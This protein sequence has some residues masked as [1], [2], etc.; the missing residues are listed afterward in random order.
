VSGGPVRSQ[1]VR[2]LLLQNRKLGVRAPE[3]GRSLA[4]FNVER[5]LSL[6]EDLAGRVALVHFWTSSRIDCQHVLAEIS[7]LERRFAREPFAVVSC[8]SPKFTHERDP[9]GVRDAI[10]RLGVAHP[11]AVECV[12]AHDESSLARRYAVRAWPTSTL[13]GPDGLLLAQISGEGQRATLEL[14]IGEALALYRHEGELAPRPLALRS[15]RS[16]EAQRA[17][18][19]PTKLAWNA[20][21]GELYVADTAQHRV[22]AVDAGG[23]CL[24]V[25]GSGEAGYEDGT[26]EGARFRAPRGLAVH[27][28]DL[29][30]AD[31]EN[32]VVRRVE[33]ASGRV[34]TLAGT[35]QLGQQR[36]VHT[37]LRQAALNSPWDLAVERGSVY[38]AMAGRHQI[39]R[40]DLELGTAEDF[41]G[42]GREARVDGERHE[43]SFAQPAGLA[44][45]SGLLMVVDAQSSALRALEIAGGRVSTPCGASASASDLSTFGDEDG[46]GL[47]PRFQ[48]PLGVARRGAEILVA[49]TYNHRIKRVDPR[50]GRVAGLA[51]T[52][53][54]GDADG[55]LASAAF[56]EPSGLAV[57]GTLVYVADAGNHAVRVIDLEHGQVSTLAL[58]GVPSPP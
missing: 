35:G 54:P 47:G 5:P 40:L 25:F 57:Q 21:R 19:F 1:E 39:W 55:P 16:A 52:G 45:H 30:I 34:G 31:A 49:D 20:A 33:L 12:S 14:L 32:H 8:H 22:V 42:D 2:A 43:C 58:H 29:L 26:A 23:R 38:V 46:V 24:N 28:G 6:C 3:I 13:V 56:R 51:G 4:W 36:F 41:A 48:Q 44:L 37:P 17:L 53:R 15:E 50:S 7:S 27:G 9:R 10:L 11:V 18:S